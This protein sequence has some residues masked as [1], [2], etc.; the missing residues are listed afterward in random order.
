MELPGTCFPILACLILF[1]ILNLRSHHLQVQTYFI[2]FSLT[3]TCNGKKPSLAGLKAG[4]TFSATCFYFFISTFRIYGY[5]S[6]FQS[7][8][9]ELYGAG[10]EQKLFSSADNLNIYHFFAVNCGFFR[11]F[12]DCSRFLL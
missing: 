8:E 10:M 1:T 3:F 5:K 12:L 7:T 2:S 4:K 11:P 9:N 6:T